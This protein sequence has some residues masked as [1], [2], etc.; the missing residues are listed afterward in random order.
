[1]KDYRFI[2]LHSFF[3]PVVMLLLYPAVSVGGKLQIGVIMTADVPY[4]SEMH[5]GFMEELEGNSAGNQE[6]EVILQRPFP[7]Q[8]AWSNAARKLIAFDVDLIVSY[9]SPATLA[10]L[11]EKS[12]IPIVY[13]GVYDPGNIDISGDNITGC[14]YKVPLSSL[15]RYLKR[16]KHVGRL[17]AIYSSIEEDSIRQANKLESLASLQNITLTKVNLRSNIDIGKIK[18]V[19][20][21]D[22]VI[23]TGSALVHLWVDDIMSVLRKEKIPVADIFPDDAEAGV[24]MTLYRPALE[25]GKNAATMVSRILEGEQPN[26]ITPVI[27][28]DAELVFN[29]IEA[30]KMG[31]TF[32]I[33]LVVEATR[34]IK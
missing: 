25:Q 10:V 12:N 16:L 15:I 6:I 34:V 14:G 21:D 24:L 20:E 3:L 23:L 33:G 29:L 17:S 30:E 31:L 26:T 8:I 13:A 1:M 4:Y 5:K 19:S 27:H 11:D 18:R 9:G 28:G 2:L 32:P 7:D 22:A